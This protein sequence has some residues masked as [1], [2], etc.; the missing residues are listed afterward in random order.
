[1]L[2][3]TGRGMLTG[4]I[5]PGGWHEVI[6]GRDGLELLIR[7]LQ[8]RRS[9][10]LSGTL[11]R[12]LSLR[13]GRRLLRSL[14]LRQ[15]VMSLAW[16]LSEHSVGYR[17]YRI[18]RNGRGLAHPSA[19]FCPCLGGQLPPNVRTYFV[20]AFGSALI[21]GFSYLKCGIVFMQ[22]V[23]KRSSTSDSLDE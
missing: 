9:L 20:P 10:T 1:M 6:G 13:V 7:L 14:R 4:R 15:I 5:V 22:P 3:L 19:R 18:H 8:G 23:V 21:P 17:L 16:R 11:L 2:R 12:R